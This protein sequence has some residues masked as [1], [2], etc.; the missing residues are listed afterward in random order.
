MA[1]SDG[2]QDAR[3]LPAAPQDLITLVQ[4]RVLLEGVSSDSLPA[5]EHNPGVL[6]SDKRV[7]MR[8]MI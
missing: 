2:G 3:L 8:L 7:H 4:D 5:G 1:P 6:R